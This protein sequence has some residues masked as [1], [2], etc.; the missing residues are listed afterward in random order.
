MSKKI[1]LTP[2]TRKANRAEF[3]AANPWTPGKT[4][5]QIRE[6]VESGEHTLDGPFVF[7]EASS[8]TKKV[9]ARKGV[10]ATVKA[11][12]QTKRTKKERKASKAKQEKFL[13][14]LHDTA[15]QRDNR[16]SHNAEASAWCREN[17][18]HPSGSAWEALKKG[19]RDVATLKALN[20][21]DGLRPVK[22]EVKKTKSG[23]KATTK[24]AAVIE[25]DAPAKTVRPRRANGTFMGKVEAETFTQLTSNGLDPEIARKAVTVLS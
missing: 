19:E 8:K 10:T 22:G 21:E 24:I 6:L 7:P 13:T 14:W 3:V 23:K 5:A 12:K 25:P 1:T 9:T 17:G 18:I 16:K 20:V 15:E 2:S 4:V 11:N